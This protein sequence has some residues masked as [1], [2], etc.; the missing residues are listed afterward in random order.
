MHVFVAVRARKGT[1]TCMC[2]EGG[3]T[4]KRRR[5]GGREE[6]KER[7]DCKDFFPFLISNLL[8]NRNNWNFIFAKFVLFC[9]K[10][11]A[12]AK[13]IHSYSESGLSI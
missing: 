2:G 6:G 3:S 5:K 9:R 4:H 11:N 7:D 12:L 10:K 13:N 8:K 1:H